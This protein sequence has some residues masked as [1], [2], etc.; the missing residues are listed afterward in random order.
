MTNLPHAVQVQRDASDRNVNILP[1][2]T[3]PQP[4]RMGAAV[5]A[6]GVTT[7]FLAVLRSQPPAPKLSGSTAVTLLLGPVMTL[8]PVSPAPEPPR[9]K[10]FQRRRSTGE[11]NRPPK[12]PEAVSRHAE[13]EAPPVQTL[14]SNASTASSRVSGRDVLQ[15]EIRPGAA[16]AARSNIGRMADAAGTYMGDVRASSSE[17]LADGVATAGKTDCLASNPNGSLLAAVVMT[18]EA[19]TGQ[20][21]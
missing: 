18:Y 13:P 9:R 1:T 16:E 11:A 20:C 14:Q 7:C 4:Q 5:L 10:T 2:W 6:I 8:A 17:R 12:A 19:A 3:A 15:L 21:K